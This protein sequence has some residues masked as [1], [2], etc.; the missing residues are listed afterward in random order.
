M[1]DKLDAPPKYQI[2]IDEISCF[3]WRAY[4]VDMTLESHPTTSILAKS[5]HELMAKVLVAVTLRDVNAGVSEGAIPSA[6]PDLPQGGET[7]P[8]A[9]GG[10]PIILTPN[11]RIITPN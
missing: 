7:N 5:L 11:K 3:S 1:N 6:A 8:T 4:L 10:V 9:N 2:R